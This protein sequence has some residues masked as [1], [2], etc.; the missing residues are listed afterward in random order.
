MGGR[1]ASSGGRYL[2][3]GTHLP[4]GSEYR[5]VY[6]SGNIKFVVPTNGQVK[7]P[8]ET[9]THGRVY[10]TIG[11]DGEPRYISYYDK[12]N[13]KMKQVDITGQAHTIDG[14]KTLP[15]THKGYIHDEKGSYEPS[16]S[17]EK[18]VE[19]V[20]KTWYNRRSK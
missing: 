5:T 17:E 2:K 20:K 1:G 3:D 6:Q 4:Y 13:K 12:R 14:K 10:V 8:L 9:M 15:H 16:P 11:S 7:A 18:M 19:R